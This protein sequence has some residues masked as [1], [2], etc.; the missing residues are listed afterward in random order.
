MV[1]SPTRRQGNVRASL[2]AIIRGRRHRCKQGQQGPD[3]RVDVAGTAQVWWLFHLVSR[4]PLLHVPTD[5]GRLF[6]CL[7]VAEWRCLTSYFNLRG[8]EF[9]C[10]SQVGSDRMTS[11]CPPSAASSSSSSTAA[12]GSRKR[13]H[14]DISADRG[15]DT[16]AEGRGLTDDSESDDQPEMKR[17]KSS[18]IGSLIA[19][20]LK[21]AFDWTFGW[22]FRSLAGAAPAA[23]PALHVSTSATTA[24]AI[25]E[26]TGS[27]TTN[28]LVSGVEAD[29]GASTGAGIICIGLGDHW[30]GGA[31]WGLTHECVRV[32]DT[33]LLFELGHK[34]DVR[35]DIFQVVQD[36]GFFVGPGDVYGGERWFNVLFDVSLFVDCDGIACC[37]VLL[38]VVPVTPQVITMSTKKIRRLRIQRA[39]LE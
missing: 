27:H 34:S 22:V 25:S 15:D 38:T 7:F 2:L 6:V 18:S 8:Y 1:V 5:M 30:G 37:S 23:P 14:S 21:L 35:N 11:I 24:A 28:D 36:G 4:M 17:A 39:R 29:V 12:G 31:Y 16:Q 13:R 33:I 19:S 20:G 32:V 9:S 26:A 3:A 10:G